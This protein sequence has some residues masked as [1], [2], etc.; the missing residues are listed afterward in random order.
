MNKANGFFYGYE[1]IKKK[2]AVGCLA[3]YPIRIVLLFF[4]FSRLLPVSLL[5]LDIG[6]TFF[7]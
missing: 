1:I 4:V 3:L 5:L 6:T 7:V 2:L